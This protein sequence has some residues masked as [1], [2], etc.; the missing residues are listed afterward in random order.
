MAMLVQYRRDYNR[1]LV[2]FEIPPGNWK[3][4]SKYK[5]RTPTHFHP[6]PR[7]QTLR[8][9][10]VTKR[11]QGR[12]VVLWDHVRGLVLSRRVRVRRLTYLRYPTSLPGMGLDWRS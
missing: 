5:R 11:S 7:V 12:W 3:Q 4:L 2:I 10:Q 8:H 1:A 6:R 9:R